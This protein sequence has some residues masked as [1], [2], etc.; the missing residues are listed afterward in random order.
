MTKGTKCRTHQLT[1][2]LS[3]GPRV[4]MELP[5]NIDSSF[6]TAGAGIS[7]PRSGF[8]SCIMAADTG[9]QGPR[10]QDKPP[11]WVVGSLCVGPRVHP[12]VVMPTW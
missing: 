9:V 1:V 2:F 7:T 11:T 4:L 6:I 10:R 12:R 3:Q 8:G 5:T